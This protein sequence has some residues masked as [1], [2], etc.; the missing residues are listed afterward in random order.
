MPNRARLTL[1]TLS[2]AAAGAFHGFTGP[3]QSG[4][5]TSAG[6]ARAMVRVSLEGVAL[7]D[8]NEVSNIACGPTCSIIALRAGSEAA[9]GFAKTLGDGDAATIRTVL[10]EYGSVE[11]T[12]YGSGLRF[13]EGGMSAVDLAELVNE[14][15]GKAGLKP[16]RSA[17]TSRREGETHGDQLERIH[18]GMVRSL[19]AGEPLIVHLRSFY[20][21][22]NK[23]GEGI[24]WHG[25]LGHFVVVTGVPKELS[26][27]ALGFTVE[28]ADPAGGKRAEMYLS[29]ETVRPFTAAEGNSERWVWKRNSPFL[30]AHAPSIPLRRQQ[31]SRHERTTVVLHHWIGAW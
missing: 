6:E 27:G 29:A 5:A 30:I 3:L 22:E 16:L 1:A 24:L 13:R 19:E 8:Q 21:A 15:R 20:A 2:L 26:E 14:L 25:L 7:P 11:S 9:R 10:D 17:Y 18:A 31:R 23:P 28:Y 12:D 4:A